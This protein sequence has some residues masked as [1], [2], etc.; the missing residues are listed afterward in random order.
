MKKYEL[1]I[2]ETTMVNITVI[3]FLLVISLM[4]LFAIDLR[5]PFLVFF[6]VFAYGCFIV[7]IIEL[8]EK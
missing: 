7:Q 2:A 8:M 3:H 5:L 6:Y 4:F 1:V